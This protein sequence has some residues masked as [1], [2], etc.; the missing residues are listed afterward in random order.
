MWCHAYTYPVR[1]PLAKELGGH[2]I[3]FLER[4]FDVETCEGERTHHLE[5]EEADDVDGIIVK[6]FKSICGRR[7]RE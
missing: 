1:F 5:R 7:L 2:E 3:R 4:P 6:G